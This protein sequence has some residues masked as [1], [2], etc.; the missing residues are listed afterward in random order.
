MARPREFDV[1]E[2]IG[3]A[4]GL[5]GERGY[6]ATSI[7]DLTEAL[8]ILRGS[9]YKVFPDKHSLL[10]TVL[11]RYRIAQLDRFRQALHQ[12]ASGAEG[13]RA[14]LTNWAAEASR[15]CLITHLAQELV[16]GNAAVTE[17][18]QRHFQ[19]LSDEL[20]ECLERMRAEGT[21]S[22]EVSISGLVPMLLA[23]LQG[24]RVLG[25]DYSTQA[26]ATI[27]LL[28]TAPGAVEIWPRNPVALAS[29]SE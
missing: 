6:H 16:P 9:L 5:F 14:A 25:K 20:A 15:G 19:Q 21:L 27:L 10:L 7:S 11:D 12:S 18:I 1:D 23:T 2:A 26:A 13:L 29:G 22:P 4:T 3:I 28:V 8:G 17:R 24:M